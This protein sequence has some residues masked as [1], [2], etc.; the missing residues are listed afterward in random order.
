MYFG[1]GGYE[2]GA[3]NQ[4]HGWVLWRLAQHFLYTGD[5]DWFAGVANSLR[6][7]CDWV[8]RQRRLTM[9]PLP[10]SRGW[11][12]GFLPAGSLEDV[13][14]FHYWLSTNALTWRGVEVAAHALTEFAHPDAARVRREADAYARDLRRGFETMR[15]HSP[16]V[17]LRDGRWVPHYPSRLYCRGRDVGWIR[18][19]LEGSVYL[20]I[21]GLYDV[22]SRPAQWILDDYQDNR[23]VR[24]PYGYPI[25]NCQHEWYDRGGFSMQPLLLAGLIP[26]LDR[27]E[28]E[29]YI[30]MFFNAWCSCYREEINAMIEHPWPFLGYANV[31]HPKTSDEANAL[32]WLRYIFVYPA[33]NALYFGRAIPRA[34]L[35]A[36]Q[37]IGL[38]CVS[39][40]FGSFSVT[41]S[42]VPRAAA[43]EAVLELTL[44]RPPRKMLVRFRHPEKKPIRSVRVNGRPHAAFDARK[45]D[46]DITGRRGTVRVIASY[47]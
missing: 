39:N 34:W 20:L 9:Q 42:P 26:Y 38:E 33:R 41:Y 36:G 28:P 7:G 45:G 24:P 21:S 25:V 8:F 14:D 6:A 35:G 13:E 2:R 17:R 11:E 40:E 12:Y 10:H 19:V 43:I 15:H 29:M 5:R 47:D 27:D 3:Y 16:L 4:H 31:A 1:A 22:R 30:R 44:S 46:V 18:E 32:M 23:Y 37:P